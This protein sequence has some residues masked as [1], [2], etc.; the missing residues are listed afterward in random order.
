MFVYRDETLELE[1]S[2]H[3][4][5]N[6]ED[7]YMQTL[8]GEAT[9]DALF[10]EVQH[11]ITRRIASWLG[12][13]F[14]SLCRYMCPEDLI[15]ECLF[16]VWRN[17]RKHDPNLSFRQFIRVRTDSRARDLYKF[18]KRESRNIMPRPLHEETD[19]DPNQLT[20]LEDA[21]R[22]EALAIL[23]DGK[24]TCGRLLE[25]H[26]V[27]KVPYRR[28]GKALGKSKSTVA[29]RVARQI[30]YARARLELE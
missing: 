30:E 11:V 29:E 4:D 9:E 10:A 5:V 18:Y 17:W 23:L 2:P 21:M 28:L 14:T 7:L 12:W 20:P 3:V 8:R 15:Q 24:H 27:E 13:R 16:H 6:L 19:H 22:E 1:R 26:Y 25:L